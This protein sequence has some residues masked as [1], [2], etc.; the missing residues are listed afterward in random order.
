MR[1]TFIETHI[2]KLYVKVLIYLSYNRI[3]IRIRSSSQLDPDS[4]RIIVMRLNVNCFIVESQT[5]N[6]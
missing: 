4:N 5:L 3:R 2:F 6:F 1:K